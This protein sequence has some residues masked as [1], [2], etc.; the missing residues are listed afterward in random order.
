MDQMETLGFLLLSNI[1]GYDEDAL[2]AHMK[3][4]FALSDDIKRKLYKNH[5]NKENPNYY[6]GFAPFI[7]NDPSYK[8]LYEIGLD[9]TKVSDKEQ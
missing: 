9:L 4:F 1:P 2:F 3:W 7:A 6:R 5:F 8:E